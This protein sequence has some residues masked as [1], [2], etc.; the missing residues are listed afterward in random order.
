MLLAGP[1]GA[2][3]VGVAVGGAICPSGAMTNCVAVGVGPPAVGPP[4]GGVSVAVPSGVPVGV[5]VA[6]SVGVWIGRVLATTT[7]RT[8]TSS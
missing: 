7:P 3:M 8:V 4:G 5:G 1:A 6:V 2:P